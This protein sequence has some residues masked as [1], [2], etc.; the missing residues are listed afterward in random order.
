[1]TASQKSSQNTDHHL[2][3]GC[4]ACQKPHLIQDVS[5]WGVDKTWK[6]KYLDKILDK[7]ISVIRSYPTE[8]LMFI[9]KPDGLQWLTAEN[10]SWLAMWSGGPHYRDSILPHSG[11]KFARW[12]HS[13]QRYFGFF[14]RWGEELIYLCVQSMVLTDYISS[15]AITLCKR[16]KKLLVGL[17]LLL[18]HKLLLLAWHEFVCNAFVHT[19]SSM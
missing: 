9:Q 12:H 3:A 16:K 19:S 13:Y 1:M 11:S 17:I 14:S 18:N 4:S 8:V 7:M 5:R 6:S 2:V 10:V 15:V